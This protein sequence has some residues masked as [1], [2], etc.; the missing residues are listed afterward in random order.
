MKQGLTLAEILITMCIIGVV[1]TLMAATLTHLTPDQ[2]KIKYLRRFDSISSI[3]KDM[4][5]NSLL[6][7][8]C[9]GEGDNSIN[10]SQHPLFNTDLGIEGR[11]KTIPA[12]G[13][14]K[15]CVGLS[16]YLNGRGMPNLN[17]TDAPVNIESGWIPS[18]TTDNG[19]EYIVSTTREIQGN[20]GIFQIDVYF[21]INGSSIGPNC[22]YNADSETEAC[23]KNPDRFKLMIA[24]DGTV[25]A[26][27][28]LG[29]EYIRTRKNYTRKHYTIPEG[30]KDLTPLLTEAKRQFELASCQLS[31][32]NQGGNGNAGGGSPSGSNNG[33]A[34]EKDENTYKCREYYDGKII[35]CFYLT[36][37]Q[38]EYYLYNNDF[39]A[40]LFSI[41]LGSRSVETSAGS[42][43][44]RS[45]N[46]RI[47]LSG[48]SYST[49][50]Q[51]LSNGERL[52]KV[53]N[54]PLASYVVDDRNSTFYF[55][56]KQLANLGT[57]YWENKFYED[58]FSTNTSPYPGNLYRAE[59]LGSVG[60]YPIPDMSWNLW[61]DYTFKQYIMF[62]SPVTSLIDLYEIDMSWYNYYDGSAI[63]K[64][65]GDFYYE[66]SCT[67]NPG[68]VACQYEYSLVSEE[69]YRNLAGTVST[70]HSNLSCT[71]DE[72]SIYMEVEPELYGG[73]II[74]KN[75]FEESKLKEC[76]QWTFHGRD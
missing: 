13:N 16:M 69:K 49:R 22:F 71:S 58:L 67:L 74:E 25:V 63:K 2:N 12:S 27:D 56:M 70:G 60:G 45:D 46:S 18:F 38:P 48:T 30:A 47:S 5:S 17:C 14:S 61:H 39:P 33:A 4:S 64:R 28:P 72:K 53:T 42:W 15:Y 50:G 73:Q 68:Q 59:L 76:A 31:N 62:S 44:S 75:S 43:A 40:G 29:K 55:N 24:S 65:L 3:T 37:I 21:D 6:Y 20:Q 66:R 41:G 34:D 19:T 54:H 26:A 36:D 23:K 51:S 52:T 11:G 32:N 8:A 7:P 57:Y 1:S 9:Q 35:N 10:C